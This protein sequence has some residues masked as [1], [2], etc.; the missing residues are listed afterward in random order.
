MTTLRLNPAL[1]KACHLPEPPRGAAAVPRPPPG[2]ALGEWALALVHTRPQ[3]L[4]IAVSN[5]THWAFCLPYAP[6]PTLQSRFGPALLQALLSLGVPPDRAR[7][8]VDHSEPWVLGRGIERST[9]GHLTQ[10]RHSV[11]WAAGEG[12]SLGA[13]NARLADHMTLKPRAGYPSAQVLRLLGGNPELVTQRQKEKSE[14]WRAAYDHAQAQIGRDEV[15]IPVALALPDEPRLEAAHQASIL[16][17]R[18][19]HNDSV[20]GPPGRTSNPGGRWIP[21]TLIVDFAD[22]DSA[23]ATFARALL[24]E[25]ATLGV[26]S[27]HL[28]NAVP[29][30]LEA[31]EEVSGRGPDR[32]DGP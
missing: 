28:A 31:F 13:I 14:N 23:T 17:M 12:L 15:H 5:A 27:L 25:V 4:V 32:P 10:Y 3:K 16:L 21:R 19:P 2:N 1:A 9:V 11:T 18:L 26:S 24:D 30:V 20:S 29:A 8:E 7:A 6:M 22:I